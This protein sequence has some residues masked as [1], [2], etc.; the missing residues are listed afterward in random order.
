MYGD[1]PGPYCVSDVVVLSHEE[2]LTELIDMTRESREP[3][4]N[5]VMLSNGG[6]NPDEVEG[7]EPGS[8]FP[9]CLVS[10]VSRPIVE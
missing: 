4:D 10:N 7:F 8:L 6:G 9:S 5:G 3:L 2:I 1:A